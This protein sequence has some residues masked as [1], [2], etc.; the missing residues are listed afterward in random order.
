V[1]LLQQSS[2][3]SLFLRP[4]PQSILPCLDPSSLDPS[5]L[6]PTLPL[7][8][9]LSIL[10]SLDPFLSQSLPPSILP[11]IDLSLNSF[12]SRSLPLSILL[13]PSLPKS[14][15]LSF[16]LSQLTLNVSVRTY[17][18]KFN[19]YLPSSNFRFFSL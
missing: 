10:T 15:D 12:L 7:S 1:I 13:D 19:S 2:Q 8:L 9:P 5:L 17:L 18:D 14:I 4:L 3:L 16:P 6:D 11:Y